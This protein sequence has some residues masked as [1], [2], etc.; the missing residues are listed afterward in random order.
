MKY[1]STR[2]NSEYF[3]YNDVLIQGL[4]SD[5]GLFVPK[6]LPK[7]NNNDL[8]KLSKLSY[9]QLA[10]EIISKLFAVG[11][12]A[13]GIPIA[14]YFASG[15]SVGDCTFFGRLAGSRAGSLESISL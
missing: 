14:P 2:N 4:S 10:G 9:S 12:T 6:T 7:F 5:G 11:R 13:A 8:K 3:N 15:L 1:I